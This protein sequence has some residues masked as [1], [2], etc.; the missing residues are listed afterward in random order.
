MRTCNHFCIANVGG[1][2]AVSD[3]RGPVEIIGQKPDFDLELAAR[4]YKCS[5]DS[6]DDYFGGKDHA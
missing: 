3:C 6:L 5:M 1:K 2:C 4:F